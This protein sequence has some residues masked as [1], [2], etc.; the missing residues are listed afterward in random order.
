[1]RALLRAW[2]LAGLVLPTLSATAQPL[3]AELFYRRP[4]LAAAVLSPSGRYLAVMPA[5]ASGARRTVLGVID[6]EGGT[7]TR[8]L[9]SYEDADIENPR[10]VND[11][12]LV[13]SISDRLRGGSDQPFGPGLFGVP[14][15]GGPVRRLIDA[16]YNV[17]TEATLIK[18]RSLDASHVLLRVIGNGGS[19]VIVGRPV[20]RQRELEAVLPMRLDVST[21]Q[22]ENLAQG[23][24]VGAKSWMFDH[25]G[26]P[27]VAITKRE[28]RQRLYWRGAG[29]TA[30]RLLDDSPSEELP[31]TPAFLDGNRGLFVRVAEGPT[32]SGALYRLDMAT[33][34]VQGDALVRTPGFNFDGEPIVDPDT[35]RMLG[36]RI[37]TDADSTVWFDAR[38]KQ[39]Q[40]AADA[41]LPGH[42]NRLS[43]RRCG[44]DD[45]IVLVD[46]YNDRDPGRLALYRAK[47]DAWEP[48]GARRA[49]VDPRTM[50]T[51]DLHRVKARDGLELPVWITTPAGPKPAK[52]RP[53]V[54]LVHGGPWVRGV[55]WRWDADAQF[56]ASRGYVVIEPEFRGSTGYGT[57]H[58]RAGW[59]Q[60][61]LA[62]QDDLVDA[63]KW[64]VD[65]GLADGSRVCVAGASYGGYATLM[66]LARDG[67]L[68]RC[69]A[70]WVGVTDPRLLFKWN[71]SNM[72][73]EARAYDLPLLIGDPERDAAQFERTTP[74]LRAAE[75]KAP[76]LLAYG[77]EDYRVPLEHGTR[78]R[79]ALKAAG[80]EPEWVVYPDEGHGWFKVDNQVDF[81]NRLAAFLARHLQP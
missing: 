41:R 36:L 3:P 67:A 12:W 13:Y 48:V 58:F 23:A 40:A 25:E 15:A 10:W 54:L 75:I 42:V 68:F 65:K 20:W 33:G 55:D 78:M 63:L 60:W 11:D 70:A 32:G 62:M 64:A 17:V 14:R 79:S 49:G 43:C 61:G 1:M 37:R 34:R 45:L 24:P 7:S 66:A 57:R 39:V 47:T 56:L 50:A 30:W 28:G 76:V 31:Y 35:G 27:R 22:T 81:A 9:A 29:E 16:R 18:S 80:N 8:L 38:M 21:G 2:L 46:S 51:L 77:A 4:D 71:R 69:G 19:E 26:Q 53:A 73:D 59:K 72:S 74:L 6:L 44:R 52:P 5:A